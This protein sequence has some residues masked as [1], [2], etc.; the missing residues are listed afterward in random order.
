MRRIVIITASAIALTACTDEQ[1]AR[2]ALDGA[3][4]TNVQ[5]HDRTGFF[6]QCGDSDSTETPFVATGP[7]GATV[8]G[9][10]CGSGG[11]GKA[12]TIR[13]T[14]TMRRPS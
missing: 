5:T 14:K 13:I 8:E 9:V 3:G 6:S 2:E 1:G 12:S 10:V 7:T 4:Y 11:W